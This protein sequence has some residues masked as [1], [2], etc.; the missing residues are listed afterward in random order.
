[1]KV[2]WQ[3]NG[4]V[5]TAIAAS[6]VFAFALAEAVAMRRSQSPLV[7]TVA[8]AAE[9]DDEGD[10]GTATFVSVPLYGSL[11][12]LTA[13]ARAALADATSG[14]DLL[15]ELASQARGFEAWPLADELL[16]R[17]LETEPGHVESLFLRGRT[18][19]D[20]G[21]RE[22]AMALYERA[23]AL[24]P[25]HQKAVYNLG[26]LTRRGGDLARA[27]AL[28]VQAA[29]ITSGR[30]K[31][32]ALHQLGLVL[33]AQGRRGEA[34]ARL[35]ESVNLRPD[36]GRV[37][38][39]LGYAEW[40]R[41]RPAEAHA[42]F[43]KA[44]ALN[45]RFADAQLA[46]GLLEEA[47]GNATRAGVHLARAVDLDPDDVAY[48]RALARHQLAGGDAARARSTLAWLA[49]HADHEADRAYAQAM[50]ARLDRD[51]ERMLAEIRRADRLRPGGYDDGIELAVTT[52]LESQRTDGAAALLDL[53][54]AR[55]A[56]S[57]DVLLV[58][59]R[60]ALRL[61]RWPQSEQLLLR[62][63]AS[64]PGQSEAWF[65]LGRVR[66]EQGNLAG[67]IE[68]YRTNIVRNPAARN[69]RLNLAVLYA[70]GGQEREALALYGEIL[71][72]HPRYTPALLNRARLHERAGRGALAAADLEAAL[73]AAPG[74]GEVRDRLARLLLDQGRTDRARELLTEAIAV[75]PADAETRLLL[76]Q[77]EL[78]AGNRAQG[79]E[80]LNRV[81]ALAGEDASLWRRLADGYRD[82]GD[83][84]AAA[85]AR[86]RAVSAG[87]DDGATTR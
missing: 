79:R 54:L 60:T 58:A 25:N 77:A 40:R 59:A 71:K 42:A 49:G 67:A 44:I 27:E 16:A 48:R 43:D 46:M 32:K 65:L 19:S 34:V 23:T 80:E 57:P 69:A 73:R 1:M 83:A 86:A 62:S 5:L 50:L 28:F 56:P 81:R 21:R 70:R 47:R 9:T 22:Q 12:E 26:V 72:T 24:S 29:G 66:T 6:A 20:L 84:G 31:S 37:W 18:Q 15:H 87:S 82:A 74:D 55:P 38:L 78:R 85:Q 35:R 63:L 68:A 8:A 52:L 36:A 3:E 64:R 17:A 41:D 45:Q 13:R 2:A 30:L 61:E 39:D 76:A 51:P 10:A 7:V 14:A 75:K 11:Q 4:V 53:L 33:E